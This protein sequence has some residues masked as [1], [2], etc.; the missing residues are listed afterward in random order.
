MATSAPANEKP[1]PSKV[2]TT[3]K[4]STKASVLRI[5]APVP[6]PQLLDAQAGDERE[7]GRQEGKD[8]RAEEAGR[9]ARQR[10]EEGGETEISR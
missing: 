6:F 7:V 9:P 2:N 3:E 4:P 8:A 10:H 1:A 5:D